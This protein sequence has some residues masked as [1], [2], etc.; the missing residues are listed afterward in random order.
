[1]Q[2]SVRRSYFWCHPR[3]SLPV[4]YPNYSLSNS[5][6][7]DHERFF[8]EMPV[9]NSQ[10]QRRVAGNES[11][12]LI[13]KYRN[14]WELGAG[15]LFLLYFLKRLDLFLG[16]GGSR[17]FSMNWMLNYKKD[18][19]KALLRLGVS[20]QGLCTIKEGRLLSSLLT[21]LWPSPPNL[22]PL[23][24]GRRGEKPQNYAWSFIQIDSSRRY[25]TS[26]R[27]GSTLFLSSYGFS[28]QP[29]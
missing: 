19:R 8:L 23:H 7:M 18:E 2:L 12:P 24:I 16:R 15:H 27:Y 1:M 28:G 14:F 11:T 22:P 29:Y 10:L 25:A 4:E 26:I 5:G 9:R 3:L 20:W 17:Q 6:R 21:S 13:A